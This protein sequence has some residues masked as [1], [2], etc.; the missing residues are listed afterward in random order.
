MTRRDDLAG[1]TAV[2]TGGASGIGR[3]I[4]S[5]L[6]A[7]GMNVVVA[8]IDR[9][10]PDVVASANPGCSLHLAATGLDV[11]HPIELIA[12]ALP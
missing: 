12:Q 1:A 4:A 11:R 9:A 3:G 10:A 5:T 2:V 8:D 7:H 6:V